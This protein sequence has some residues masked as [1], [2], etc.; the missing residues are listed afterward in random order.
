MKAII[1]E[2]AG[3]NFSSMVLREID[4]QEPAPHELKV[5]MISSRINPVDMDLM[6]GFPSLKYKNP[7]IGGVDGAAVVMETGNQVNG[8]KP[9]DA[10]LFYRLFTDIGSWAEEIT[11]PAA[12]CAKIPKS[13]DAREAG[14]FGL[15]LLTAY[16]S[17]QQLNSK[18]GESILIHG[19]GGAV[20]FQ[21]L[22]VAK[23]LGLQVIGT[24]H[25]PLFANNLSLS[26]I[27]R[28]VIPSICHRETETNLDNRAVRF[29][30]SI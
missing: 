21:A 3:K 7:Q 20:G 13:I 5:K 9:G 27:L 8:F 4:P 2:K 10:V 28:V 1:R 22:Q 24:L 25:F 17:L 12:Y 23:E 11:I 16:D 6:K 30:R 26:K 15:A 29:L 19:V 18:P 14:S